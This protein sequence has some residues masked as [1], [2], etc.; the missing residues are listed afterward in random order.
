[1][2]NQIKD[3]YFAEL[4]KIS[5]SHTYTKGTSPNYD[6]IVDA[7]ATLNQE[8]EAGIFIIMGNDIKAAFRK[9]PDYKSA[10]EGEILYTGQ[11]GTICGLPCLYAKLVPFLL[12]TSGRRRKTTHGKRTGKPENIS[13]NR[14]TP[15]TIAWTRCATACKALPV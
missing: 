12:Y 11:F 4:A 9:D 2:S 10:K 13:I 7:L 5:N 6:T 15:I 14:L 8:V 3:E 1:M